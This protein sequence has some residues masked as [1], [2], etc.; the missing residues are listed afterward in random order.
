M[1]YVWSWALLAMYAI[2][3]LSAVDSV[4][5]TR[6]SQGAIAWSLSLITFPYIAVPLY[7][8]FGR[9]KFRGY[10]ETKLKV[11]QATASISARSLQEAQ[12][13]VVHE[14][15]HGPDYRSLRSLARMH[16]TSGNR[17]DL[18]IDG[19][20]TFQSIFEGIARATEYVLVEFYIIRD[21]GLGRRLRDAL[22]E[23]AQAGVRVHVLY[24]EIGSLRLGRDYLSRLRAAGVHVSA[25]NTRRGPRNRFQLNFRNHRKIVVVDGRAA[26]IGGFNV[27]DEYLGLDPSIGRW[28]DTHVR[29]TGP[30]ALGAQLTFCTDWYW[31]TRQML[32][33]PW[34]PHLVPDATC[35]VLVFPS[36]PSSEFQSA[37]LFFLQAILAAKQR[38]WIASPYFVPDEGMIAALQLAGLRGVDVRIL[39]PDRSDNRL[40]DFASWSYKEELQAAG[41]RI[42]R[43][44]DGFLHQ[45]VLVVD[46]RYAAVGTAN[47]DNRSFRLNFEVTCVV[48]QERFAAEVASMLLRDFER[49]REMADDEVASKPMWFPFAKRFARLMAP[50]L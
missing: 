8:V 5:R 17:V 28:R 45:K 1:S 49:S 30:A 16:A 18:L 22:I 40:V 38:L 47:F 13:Y 9:T 35:K 31:A 34:R 50:I 20:A 25:F 29:V 41:V 11:E 6:T 23:R 10:A 15:D 27:G 36:D 7:W 46:D 33:L 24:D 12:E 21:D 48:A 42:Y 37:G 2:G 3:V 32:P 44:K 43:Y 26:W 19:E 39:V 14:D 4:L